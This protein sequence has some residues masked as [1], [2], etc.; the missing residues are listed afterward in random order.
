MAKKPRKP[1][2]FIVHMNINGMN[3][4]MLHVPAPRGKSREIL[5][6]Y[7]HHSSLERWWGA[8]EVLNQYGSVTV[9]DL[10]GFGGMDSFYKINKAPT[11]DNLADYLASFIKLRFKKR[12]L[13]IVGLS[14]GFVVVT[15]MLQRY[16]NMSKNVDLLIS[17]AG[18]SR[19]DDFAFSRTRHAFY[20]WGTKLFS[21]PLPATIF[22]YI[23]LNP[24]ILRLA[25]ARTHN[26]Q[27]KF[28]ELSKKDKS[29]MMDFEIVLWHINDIRTH[30][31]TS[32]EFLT[33]DNCK[34]RVD[35]PL[36]HVSIDADQY[37]DKQIVEQHLKIIFNDVTTAVS[38]MTAHA[39]SI[40]ADKKTAAPLLP[41]S[42]R[43]VL[44]KK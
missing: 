15:R 6:I 12:K 26:A 30:M 36:H 9:P 10:P 20:R 38:K 42:I 23:P 34:Q 3:G 13:T 19:Y 24:G 2:D 1:A 41:T 29:A 37:F 22:K 17:V 44:A 31:K 39:P 25:Y 21:Y 14:F 5:F 40:I 7:G 33:L 16:P 11:I 28:S 35:I 32:Y 43:R 4:R 18:F 8:I 27:Q